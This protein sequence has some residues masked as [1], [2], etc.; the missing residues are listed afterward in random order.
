[1]E[2]NNDVF[3]NEKGRKIQSKKILLIKAYKKNILIHSNIYQD[4]YNLKKYK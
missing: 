2:I 4:V 1:M 3:K